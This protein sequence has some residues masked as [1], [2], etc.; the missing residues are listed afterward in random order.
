MPEKCAAA[1]VTTK[2][3]CQA[4][5]RTISTLFGRRNAR[6]NGALRFINAPLTGGE[7]G[8]VGPKGPN[9]REGLEMTGH[10]HTD[11]TREPVLAVRDMERFKLLFT[12]SRPRIPGGKLAPVALRTSRSLIGERARAQE[13]PLLT[14]G[15]V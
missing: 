7:L 4:I 14:K 12:N 10:S 11:D 15:S 8:D 9:R 5:D 1:L 13:V 3:R 2:L 6:G